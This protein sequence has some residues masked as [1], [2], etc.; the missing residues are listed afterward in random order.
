[1]FYLALAGQLGVDPIKEL[2]HR[3][4]KATLQLLVAG[5]AIT[6]LK[7]FTGINAIRIRRAL[8]L[9]AFGLVLLHFGVWAMLDVQLLAVVMEDIGQRPF[10]ALGMITMLVMLPLAL[11]SSTYAIVRMGKNWRRLHRLT[12]LI[13][14]L[15]GI[16]YIWGTKGNQIEPLVYAAI[17]CVLLLLRVRFRQRPFIGLFAWVRRLRSTRDHTTQLK[18]AS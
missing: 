14:V 9:S 15:A 10:I 4:G 5:L 3:Y 16:H 2:E 7:R 1:M 12:Y 13:A 17:I 8:G 11:T 18:D 6:P